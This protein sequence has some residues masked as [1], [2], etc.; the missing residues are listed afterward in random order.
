[1]SNARM[2]LEEII[3]ESDLV[4]EEIRKQQQERWMNID[5]DKFFENDDSR[6]LNREL[7]T[8]IDRIYHR[9][10]KDDIYL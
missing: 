7:R 5:L 1:M 9:R 3:E 2:E 8:L 6:E 10:T 4:N